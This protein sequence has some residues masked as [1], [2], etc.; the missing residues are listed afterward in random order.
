MR[1]VHVSF[2]YF[3]DV[4]SDVVHLQPKDK[5]LLQADPEMKEAEEKGRLSHPWVMRQKIST[6][7]WNADHQ[8]SS[9]GGCRTV[10][11]VWNCLHISCDAGAVLA[12]K[13]LYTAEYLR[14]RSRWV[15]GERMGCRNGWDAG[16]SRVMTWHGPIL[17]GTI[18]QISNFSKLRLARGLARAAAQDWSFV[19][20]VTIESAEWW[21]LWRYTQCTTYCFTIFHP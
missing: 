1:Y 11:I 8:S 9:I 3:T 10:G 5:R 16:K 18:L 21:A 12:W 14:S 7:W 17:E 15:T 20:R 13:G 19:T 4:F 2:Q 6:L